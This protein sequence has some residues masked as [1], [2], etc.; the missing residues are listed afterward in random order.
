MSLCCG[1]PKRMVTHKP[2]LDLK[3]TVVVFCRFAL[4]RILMLWFSDRLGVYVLCTC[5]AYGTSDV[6]DIQVLF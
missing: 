6:I 5:V 4:S 1:M 3:L 2:I